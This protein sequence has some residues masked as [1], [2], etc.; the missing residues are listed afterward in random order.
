MVGFELL[1][2]VLAVPALLLPFLSRWPKVS[3]LVA[4]ASVALAAA[5]HALGLPHSLSGELGADTFTWAV[6]AVAML[7]AL[8]A[9]TGF[10]DPLREHEEEVPLLSLALFSLLGVVGLAYAGTLPMFLASWV[11]FSAASYAVVALAKDKFSAAGATKYGLMSVASSSLLLLALAALAAAT[12]GLRLA[13]VGA[14]APALAVVAAALSLAAMGF[15]IGVFPFHAWLPDVYGVSDPLPVS[16][17]SALSKSAAVIAV[18]KVAQVAAPALGVEWLALFGLAAVLT[19][20]YGN[21][22]ALLQRGF[23]GLLA[24]SSIAHAGYILVGLSAMS[25]QGQAR[26]L[27]LYGLL[28]QLIAYSFAKTGLFLLARMLRPAGASPPRL[29]DLRG[30]SGADAVSSAAA[31]VLV[32]SLMGIPPLAGFW[33]KLY[34]FLSVVQQAPWLTAAALLNTGIG[35]AYYARLVKSMYFESGSPAVQPYRSTRA[36]L[37]ACSAVTVAAGLLPFLLPPRAWP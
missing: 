14:A 2:C 11:L 6:L 32:L 36:A 33:G 29:D 8:A 7:D 21:V 16:L 9:L 3:R 22:T 24:Y 19:M 17:V 10:A 31:L 23:Q 18:Y 4:L 28:M 25:L 35:A 26:P 34:L 37:V 1:V 12:G 5:V 20:T 15:K 27:A 13:A 30:L